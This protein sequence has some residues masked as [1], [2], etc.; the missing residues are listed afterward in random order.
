MQYDAST[1]GNHDFDSG[2]EVYMH[3]C[4]MLNWILICELW[5]QNTMM[6]A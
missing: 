3:K 2:I 4:L 1:I 6:D 5:F